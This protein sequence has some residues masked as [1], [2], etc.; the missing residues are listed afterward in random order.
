MA[1][2]NGVYDEN[3][4]LPSEFEVFEAGVNPTQLIEGDIVATKAGDGKLYKFKAEIYDGENKGRLVFGQVNLQNK[5]ATA[6][7]IGQSEF[8]AI[9][10]VTGVPNPED[11]A[12]LNF[13]AFDAVIEV[14]PAKT[15]NGQTYKARNVINW[16]KTAKLFQGEDVTVKSAPANDNAAPAEEKNPVVA[17]K[18]A[19]GAGKKGA[20]PR[21][22]A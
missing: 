7:K 11:T 3:A 5:N 16:A 8:A 9:R 22:A 13:K 17:S 4:E 21:K 1:S 19:G 18:P 15:V 10:L 12:D 20:W 14:E 6:T 2:L